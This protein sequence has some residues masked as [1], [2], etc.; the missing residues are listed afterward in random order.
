MR[1][2]NAVAAKNES[3]AVQAAARTLG[4]QLHVLH[5]ST[6]RD[7]DSVFASLVRLRASA[8]LIGSDLFFTSRSK[9]L[10]EC[11]QAAARVC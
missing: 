7:F 10:A 5:A 1:D 3:Q 9:Q 11:P 6:E 2:P 8:L 4:L